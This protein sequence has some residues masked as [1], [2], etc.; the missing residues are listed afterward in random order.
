MSARRR[1]VRSNQAQIGAAVL[2]AVAL[3]S[4]CTGDDSTADVE[5]VQGDVVAA[6]APLLDEYESLGETTRDVRRDGVT[7]LGCADGGRR[8]QHQVVFTY[9]GGSD[10]TVE[11]TRRVY[12]DFIAAHPDLDVREGM[13]LAGE[14][15]T[16]HVQDGTSF[17]EMR[18]IIRDG[19]TMSLIV[20]M[21]PAA[22]GGT[23]VSVDAH[24]TCVK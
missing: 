3:T 9:P 16:D 2:A 8:A 22:D 6:V 14:A 24:T 23:V 4:A 5:T 15:L 11:N 18:E 7:E 13:N 20:D 12:V 19:Y 21:D 17:F 1:L 10:V